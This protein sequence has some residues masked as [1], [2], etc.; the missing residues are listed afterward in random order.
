MNPTKPVNTAKVTI[1]GEELVLKGQ[2]SEEYM[3][4]IAQEVSLRMERLRAMYPTMVRHRLAV[5]AAIYLADELA[6]L[7]QEY[8]RVLD[9]AKEAR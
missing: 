3:Q 1:C 5:L 2:E 9:A 7:R 8:S 6:K 4:S